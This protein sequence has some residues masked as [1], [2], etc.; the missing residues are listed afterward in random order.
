MATQGSDESQ[1]L[2]PSLNIHQIASFIPVFDG[3]F[4]IQ[5]FIEEIR[6]AKK[7][8]IGQIVLH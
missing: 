8:G 1:A 2:P 4:P 6:D 7:W 3:S 5:D